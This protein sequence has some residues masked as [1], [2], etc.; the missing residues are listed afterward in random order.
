MAH[1]RQSRP[2]NMAYIRQTRPVSGLVFQVQVLQTFQVVPSSLGSGP[3]SA[4]KS[5]TTTSARPPRRCHPP[6]PSSAVS[7]FTPTP[8]LCRCIAH[9]G[10]SRANMAHTRQSRPDSG[11]VFH[12]QVLETFEAVPLSLRSGLPASRKSRT[13][14]SARPPRRCYPPSFL[15]Q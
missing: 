13:T 8:I 3:P 1:I 7:C 11:L 6:S 10:R 5:R 2:A 4:R 12:V 15:A 9:E 14:T